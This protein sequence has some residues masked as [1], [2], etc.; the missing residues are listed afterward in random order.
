MFAGHIGVGLAIARAEP[1][2]NAGVFI[3]AALWLDVVLWVLV[4]T[5]P[6]SVT[7]PADFA[8]THQA[9]FVFP[10]SH[11]LAAA[12]VWSLLAGVAFSLARRGQAPGRL[13]SGALVGFAVLSHWLLDALVHR[14]EL[15]VVG[16]G[17]RMLGLGLW[18][19]MPVALVVEAALVF[20][21]VLLFLQ[22][23]SLPRGRSIALAALAIVVLVFTVL[24]MTVA[25][26]PPSAAAM[27]ASSLVT[28]VVVCALSGWLGRPPG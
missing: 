8:T 16:A 5:G 3:A 12:I 28:L 9:E 13:R 27:A 2:V 4:L 10:Y 15:P 26:P 19:D 20:A 24:G 7:V 14:P 23:A 11:G 25:P 17:S 21:G 1:R 6:E 18:N 22:G